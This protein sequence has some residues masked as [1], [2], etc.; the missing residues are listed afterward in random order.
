MRC[1]CSGFDE[2]L[3]RV[4]ALDTRNRRQRVPDVQAFVLQQHMQSTPDLGRHR[5][6]SDH[7]R[8]T[9]GNSRLQGSRQRRPRHQVPERYSREPR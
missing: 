2:Y 9:W 1:P 7:A 4:V 5:H 3:L 6:A 8:G